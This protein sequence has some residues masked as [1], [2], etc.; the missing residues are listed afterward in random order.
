MKQRFDKRELVKAVRAIAALGEPKE[1][2]D[3]FF[4]KIAKDIVEGEEYR[5]LTALAAEIAPAKTAVSL[6]RVALDKMI[7]TNGTYPILEETFLEQTVDKFANE[8]P[9]YPHIVHALIRRESAFDPN[10][11]SYAGA[12]G[13]MQVIDKTAAVTIQKLSFLC[14]TDC[15][16]PRK[17]IEPLYNV[18]IGTLY[19]K[20]LLEKYKGSIV[21]ALCG[22]NAGP[23]AVDNL[24]C[25][26]I[27]NP[28]EQKTNMIQ[29]IELIPYGETRNYVMRVLESFVMYVERAKQKNPSI[30]QYRMI[31]LINLGTKRS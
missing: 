4:Q 20:E 25:T 8:N 5:L 10:A 6:S 12:K 11:I 7:I 13:L 16:D 15:K 3:L 9:I 19:F 14:D 18:A 23:E 22:Y 1:T 30:K 28:L 24:F 17:Y 26:C 29:W 21:L 31:D 27:G 2:V